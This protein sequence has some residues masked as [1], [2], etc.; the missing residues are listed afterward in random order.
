MLGLHFLDAVSL[1]QFALCPTHCKSCQRCDT[2]DSVCNAAFDN[3]DRAN[4]A[5][6]GTQYV[7]FHVQDA[8]ML[9]IQCL[10]P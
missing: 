4:Q 1:S 7:C 3:G 8:Y 6:K 5:G 9:V 2:P 10:E